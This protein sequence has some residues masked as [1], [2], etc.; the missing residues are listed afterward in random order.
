MAV[1]SDGYVFQP[2]SVDEIRQ[3]LQL[4]KDVGRKVVLRGAGLSY[5]DASI[6][7]EGIVLDLSEMR[8][9]LS[10]DSAAGIAN[11]EPGVT[12]EDLWRAGLPNGWWPP[13]VSGTMFVTLGGALAMNIH[14]KNNF[15]AGT[16]GEHVLDIDVLMTN[17][18]QITVD[19]D[20]PLFREVVS[21][22]GLLGVITRVRIQLKK[23]VSGNLRVYAESIPN[24]TEQIEAFEK[25]AENAD[26]MVSWVDCFAKGANAGRGLFHAAWHNTEADLESLLE[27][28]QDL[29]SK[30]LGFLPKREVWRVLKPLNNRLGMKLLN[31]IKYWS[32][33]VVGN[34]Q[35]HRQGLVPFSFL[36]DYVPNWKNAYLPGGFIQ[37][38]S[39]IPKEKAAYVFAKQIE[40]AQAAGQEPYLGVLKKHR[41]EEFLLRHGVDGFSFAMDFKVGDQWPSLL[42]LCHQMNELVT[43]ANGRFYL[44]KDATLRPGD[45]AETMGESLARLTELKR[46]LDPEN[47]LSSA[48]ANRV[49][50]GG[51]GQ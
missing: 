8:R 5:G 22:A 40:L 25:R 24:W 29:P 7:P 2:K 15:R 30:I 36:L 39:F 17:G 32:S 51:S 46:K 44:A 35:F 21:S 50:L 18:E 27:L 13:V 49:G 37:Y 10:W 4:A 28:S 48:L 14:G 31:A 33:T 47:R 11:C 23:V 38:Q 42:A 3:V 43:S 9:F 12:I 41:E 34:R 45:Y 6:L 26:Y 16:I 20:E 1:R 19:R